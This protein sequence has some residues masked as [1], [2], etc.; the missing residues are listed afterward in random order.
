[1]PANSAHATKS[2]CGVFLSFFT[3]FVARDMTNIEEY[4]DLVGQPWPY[5]HCSDKQ[6]AFYLAG[7][8]NVYCVAKNGTQARWY[9]RSSHTQ[10]LSKLI[11]QQKPVRPK[12][13]LSI[14]SPNVTIMQRPRP[15]DHHSQF[16]CG[17]V[18]G[19]AKP[20]RNS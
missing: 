6:I 5:A 18:V 8:E 4:C 2:S 12:R 9:T 15:D 20:I 13:V 19:D 17:G 1:M 11:R 16:R 3:P 7:M 10:H 14:N